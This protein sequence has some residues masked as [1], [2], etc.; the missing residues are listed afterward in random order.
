[1]KPTLRNGKGLPGKGGARCYCCV[2]GMPHRK[3]RRIIRHREA[4]ILQKL[5]QEELRRVG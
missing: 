5:V 4:Q 1:M 3:N 2:T